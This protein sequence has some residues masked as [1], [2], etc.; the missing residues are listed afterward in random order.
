MKA[1]CSRLAA[2]VVV[3]GFLGG[4][5]L[6]GTRHD[7]LAG[8]GDPPVIVLPSARKAAII[9]VQATTPP[10]PAPVAPRLE[11][12]PPPSDAPQ[13]SVIPIAPPLLMPPEK[14]L[15]VQPVVP[16]L[17]PKEA[18][19]ETAPP[20]HTQAVP[21][22][23]EVLPPPA[24]RPIPELPAPNGESTMKASTA[25][26]ITAMIAAAPAPAPAQEAVKPQDVQIVKDQIETLRKEIAALNK[27][28]ELKQIK[29]ELDALKKDLS[30]LSAKSA[31]AVKNDVKSVRDDIT[32]LK[33]D[34]AKPTDYVKATDLKNIV[35]DLAAIKKELAAISARPTGNVKDEI[36]SLKKDIV[37]MNTFV[38]ESLEGKVEKGFTHDGVIKRLQKLDESMETLTRKVAAL[39]GKVVSGSSPIPRDDANRGTVR[40]VNDYPIE[41]AIIVNGVSYRLDPNTRKDIPV[42]SG[43]FKYQLLT[44]GGSEAERS[45]KDGETVTLTIR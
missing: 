24:A 26:A 11:V 27:A 4:F 10:A 3:G 37:A 29:D 23:I 1:Q 38:R 17:T 2:G 43:S 19:K 15:V 21:K 12:L 18:P 13:K 25:A 30:S 8:P 16:T 41:I 42:P 14:P 33:A 5:A 40:I 36:E 32:A 34:I 7:L 20:P 31:E 6:L 22:P 28:A 9:P 35:D 44:S 45:I 39:D